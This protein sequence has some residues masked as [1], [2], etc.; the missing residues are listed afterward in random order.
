VLFDASK[1]SVE[2][3][4]RQCIEVVAEARRYGAAVEGEIEGFKRTEDVVGDEDVQSSRRSSTSSAHR[5][6]RVRPR[7]RTP[8]GCTAPDGDAS[9]TDIVRPGI[10]VAL[11]GGGSTAAARVNIS[12]P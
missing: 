11:H 10:P 12:P 3:N 5:R 2:E 9:V 7:H 6:G 1:L 4:K 8:T